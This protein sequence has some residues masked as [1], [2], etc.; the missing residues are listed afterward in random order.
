V[1][2]F[3]AQEAR[4]LMLARSERSACTACELRIVGNG[5]APNADL[6]MQSLPLAA[7]RFTVTAAKRRLDD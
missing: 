7:S 2:V 4:R 1:W 3:E 6:Q 5:L